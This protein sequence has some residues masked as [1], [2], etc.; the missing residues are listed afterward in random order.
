[1][2][3]SNEVINIQMANGSRKVPHLCFTA[4]SFLSTQSQQ[5]ETCLRTT[6]SYVTLGMS[7]CFSC[8]TLFL[9]SLCRT[10]IG[11]SSKSLI[12]SPGLG[13]QMS[14]W[15]SGSL[16]WELSE[17][18]VT[19]PCSPPNPQWLKDK[20]SFNSRDENCLIA[21][22][23]VTHRYYLPHPHPTPNSKHSSENKK[24]GHI[25]FWIFNIANPSY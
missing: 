1:M 18:R 9:L 3:P 6:E 23:L 19:P 16:N 7:L 4:K 12:D 20:S 22:R 21:S 11:V 17:A 25:S 15:V 2:W 8:V 14:I 24:L 13:L 5:T 10:D